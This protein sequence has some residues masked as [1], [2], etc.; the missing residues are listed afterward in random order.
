[1]SH[2]LGRVTLSNR[3]E[4]DGTLFIILSEPTQ[5][6]F[7]IYNHLP[8]KLMLDVVH[9]KKSDEKFNNKH[10]SKVIEAAETKKSLK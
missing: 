9:D 2:Y 10:S 8:F 1:V 5:P 7:M 3:K 4:D 6:E